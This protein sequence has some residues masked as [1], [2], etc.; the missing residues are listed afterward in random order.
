MQSK[1][2][3]RGFA[4]VAGEIGKL[5]DQSSQTVGNI[6]SIVQEV[7]LAVNDMTKS[8]AKTLDFL[9]NKVFYL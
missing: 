2:A 4:V 7:T 5:A 6:T 3:G 1:E 9:E 8:L